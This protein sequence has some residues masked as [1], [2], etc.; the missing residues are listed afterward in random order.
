MLAAISTHR[1]QG[2]QRFLRRCGRQVCIRK[3]CCLKQGVGLQQRQEESMAHDGR[4]REGLQSST[5]HGAVLCDWFTAKVG[6]SLSQFLGN[7]S[8]DMQ[9]E[10]LKIFTET[11]LFWCLLFIAMECR[12]QFT[13]VQEIIDAL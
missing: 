13:I 11:E 12:P 5:Q 10:T 9:Q 3:R 7:I 8:L 4:G 2:R 1:D 6:R